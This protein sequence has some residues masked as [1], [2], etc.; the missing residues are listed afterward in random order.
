MSRWTVKTVP[1]YPTRRWYALHWNGEPLSYLRDGRTSG[2]YKN[3]SDAEKRASELNIDI[4]KR[5]TP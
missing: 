3:R 1:M 2:R 5:K 4:E